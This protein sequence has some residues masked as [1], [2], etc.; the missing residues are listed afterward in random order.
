MS[1]T[2]AIEQYLAQPP[3]HGRSH[4]RDVARV[5]ALCGPTR[6]FDYERKLWATRCTDA[7]RALVASKKWQPVG[8]DKGAYAPLM[9]A[10]AEHRAKL[11]AQWQAEEQARKA[12][13]EEERKRLAVEEAT[14]L[15]KRKAREAE[16]AIAELKAK[17]Q[18][19]VAEAKAAA[20]LP[21]ARRR[22]EQ[23]LRTLHICPL[24]GTIA[25]I[26]P[27]EPPPATRQPEKTKAKR[28]G[29]EPSE[30]E[31]AECAR[32]GFAA[33]AIAF[34]QRLLELGPRG[35]LSDEGRVLRYC[36]LVFEHDEGVRELTRE[37]RARSWGGREVRWTLPEAASRAYANELNGRAREASAEAGNE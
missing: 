25:P 8:I 10:A 27:R 33:Q 21:F 35:S 22:Y 11:E 32:L 37:E 1:S 17:R 14:R 12:R 30:A 36:G 23:L 13:E 31:V 15:S 20:K 6:K 24:L 3:Y 26:E 16:A 29:L 7:L 19:R 4:P 9:R 34:S 18:K 5:K 28:D 2:T